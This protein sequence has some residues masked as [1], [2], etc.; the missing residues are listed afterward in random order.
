MAD[1]NNDGAEY[2]IRAVAQA[3]GL[4][5]ETLRAWERRYRVI[6]PR[7]GVSGHRIYSTRDVS[8]LRRLRETTACG[9]SISKI[10]HLSDEELQTLLR[11][12][13]AADARGS[14]AKMLVTRLMRAVEQYRPEECDQSIAMAFALLPPAQV[15]REVLAPALQEAGSDSHRMTLRVSTI[16]SRIGTNARCQCS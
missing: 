12:G 4:S 10:A 11:D 14:A 9:H 16:S 8:R 5:V 13:D 6:E 7:R 15:I 1:F 3:T 2:S